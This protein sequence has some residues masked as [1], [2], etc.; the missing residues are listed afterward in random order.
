MSGFEE[1]QKRTGRRS[2]SQASGYVFG[3]IVILAG[4]VMLLSTMGL[5]DARSFWDYIP[6]V[7]VV[8]GITKVVDGFRTTSILFGAAMAAVGTLWFLDNI[9][10]LNFNKRI[11]FPSFI[12]ALGFVFLL[13]TFE[14]ER[15]TRSGTGVK[16]ENEVS[17]WTMFG[18]IK[19]VVTSPDFRG[20]D[21]FA[22]F[23]GI[24]LDLRRA[25][26]V[27]GAVVDASVVFGGVEI[28]VPE[29]WNVDVK[30]VAILGGFEDKTLHPAPGQMSP[31]LIVTGLALFGGVTV[32]NA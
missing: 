19:R 1:F 24:E 6:L 4:T 31:T 13:R 9:D 17:L 11:L 26:L 27:D 18:G 21:A 28:K 20:G 22:M 8:L 3:T 5:I 16:S 2:R 10:V 29:S 25:A 15:I 30:G 23:G 32:Q 7:L 14:R 12:I